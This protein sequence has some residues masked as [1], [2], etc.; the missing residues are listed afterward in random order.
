MKKLTN[1]YINRKKKRK[2]KPEISVLIV[3]SADISLNKTLKN[4]SINKYLDIRNN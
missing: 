3:I 2:K 4:F 1:K